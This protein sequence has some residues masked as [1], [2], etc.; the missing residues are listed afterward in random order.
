MKKI[1]SL[2]SNRKAFS[3][4]IAVLLMATGVNVYIPLVVKDLFNKFADNQNFISSVY[5]L[6]ILLMF[7]VLILTSGNA[8]LGVVGEKSVLFF[9]ES[10]VRGVESLKVKTAQNYDTVEIA[11]HITNDSEILGKITSDTLPSIITSTA[12]WG[13]SIAMLFFI[14]WRMTILILIGALSIGLVIKIIGA[15]MSVVAKA[16]RNQLA[17]LTSKIAHSIQSRLDIKI[18]DAEE[19]FSKKV[20]NDNKV[21][22]Q[23]SITGIKY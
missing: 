11:N 20:E 19:W 16:F 22:Y 21:L 15:K 5:V 17:N 13:A 9:R 10:L 6:A 23:T 1:Y 2:I 12:S 8:I 4:G 14:D 7:N 18:N 3:L